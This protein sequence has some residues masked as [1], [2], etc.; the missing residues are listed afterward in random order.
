GIYNAGF[1]NISILDIAK[2]VTQ[3]V[4]AEIVVSDSNDPRSYRQNS[5]KLLATGFKQKYSVEDGIKDVIEA[6][7]SGKIINDDNCYNIRTM[8]KLKDIS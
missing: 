6:Y 1:E 3:F 7:T 8:K 5:D 4:P 2:K